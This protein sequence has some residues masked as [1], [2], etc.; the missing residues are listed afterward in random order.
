MC[1]C[2]IKVI[3]LVGG[4]KQ[5]NDLDNNHNNNKNYDDNNDDDN[6]D[7]DEKRCWNLS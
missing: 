3:G 7:N 1:F 5:T 6:D 2:F 4:L